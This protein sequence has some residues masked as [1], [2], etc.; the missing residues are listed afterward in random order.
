MKNSLKRLLRYLRANERKAILINSLWF[1]FIGITIKWQLSNI[2]FLSIFA[3]LFVVTIWA[4]A[5]NDNNDGGGWNDE[6][7]DNPKEPDPDPDDTNKLVE[8]FI[9]ESQEKAKNPVLK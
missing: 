3:V 4:W 2:V 9:R 5:T 6:G 7:D 8:R 1:L